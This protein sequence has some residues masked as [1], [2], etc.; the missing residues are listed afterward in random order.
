MKNAAKASGPILRAM[1]KPSWDPMSDE[2][3]QLT[4]ED[5]Q[6][7]SG[8]NSRSPYR[9]SNNQSVR[10]G[11][12]RSAEKDSSIVDRQRRAER[13]KAADARLEAVFFDEYEQR[14][15]LQDLPSVLHRLQVS[16]SKI[17]D[18]AF[19]DDLWLKMVGGVPS[20]YV[21]FPH[22]KEALLEIGIGW[23]ACSPSRSSRDRRPPSPSTRSVD[24]REA[25][26]RSSRPPSRGPQSTRSSPIRR[27]DAGSRNT[28]PHAPLSR[29]PTSTTQAST[30]AASVAR[31]DSSVIDRLLK[32]TAS[33]QARKQEVRAP[34]SDRDRPK[35]STSKQG[36]TNRKATALSER[37]HNSSLRSDEVMKSSREYAAARDAAEQRDLT[38]KPKVNSLPNDHEPSSSFDPSFLE[39]RERYREFTKA[40]EKK[41]QPEP[42]FDEPL[43]SDSESDR[44]NCSFQPHVNPPFR[45]RARPPPPTAYYDTVVKM[46]HS[47][48]RSADRDIK[49]Q[50][51][52]RRPSGHRDPNEL[53]RKPI[54]TLQ[55][56][57]EEIAISPLRTDPRAIARAFCDEK[58]IPLNN[59]RRCEVERTVR[60]VI[61]QSLIPRYRTKASE[62]S[63][64]HRSH[65]AAYLRRDRSKDRYSDAMGRAGRP[66]NH[67]SASASRGSSLRH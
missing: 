52:L 55:I 9:R 60:Y 49:L 16:R 17:E 50:E 18:E 51:A 24:Q 2:L 40:W 53:L 48:A 44:A 41:K 39:R 61:E 28:S 58:G 13:R 46:R 34:S 19:I 29:I 10:S 3:S 22:F 35:R 14:I 65:E 7:E 31:P 36:K 8:W 25:S 32:P 5:Y 66:A 20:P 42:N 64:T 33:S 45:E 23:S 57:G 26:Q 30:V 56:D 37:L 21:D 1:P 59:P 67:R 27:S 6:G 11:K 54:G 62:K 43:G 47:A 38:F 4:D 15:T 63:Y 12:G